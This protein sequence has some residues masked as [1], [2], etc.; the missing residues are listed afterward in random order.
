MSKDDTPLIKRP[1][2]GRTGPNRG[3]AGALRR[4]TP[5]VDELEDRDDDDLDDDDLDDDDLD[6]RDHDHEARLSM[7]SAR[8]VA[9]KHDPYRTRPDDM[10]R[11]YDH[12]SQS[13]GRRRRSRSSE[14][15]LL[16]LAGAGTQA[17]TRLLTLWVD[18]LGPLLPP[19]LRPGRAGRRLLARY[20]DDDL[21]RRDEGR[22]DDNGD[23]NGDDHDDDRRGR[24]RRQPVSEELSISLDVVSRRPVRVSLEL[25]RGIPAEPL[26]VR[27]LRATG[28]R[29]T[30]IRGAIVDVDGPDR[31][32]VH[33]AIPDKLPP[34]TYEGAVLSADGRE[35]LG[36]LRVL[37]RDLPD[38][39]AA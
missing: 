17:I 26:R 3:P 9:D 28:S 23:D 18:L 34:G 15:E 39:P 16:D 10:K 27:P 11:G 38:E 19:A 33:L 22:H 12:W 31:V 32:V 7:D 14:G 8:E 1:T 35:R 24:G 25:D 4:S 37:L 20:R 21:G 36:L 30:A 6:R 29:A 5:D 13:S 2:S